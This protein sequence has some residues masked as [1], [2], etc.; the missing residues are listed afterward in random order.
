MNTDR[1]DSTNATNLIM[2]FFCHIEKHLTVKHWFT[3]KL[4]ASKFCHN[5]IPNDFL[6]LNAKEDFVVSYKP[7]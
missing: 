5:F 4:H 6:L 2:H 1:N 7:V 3:G